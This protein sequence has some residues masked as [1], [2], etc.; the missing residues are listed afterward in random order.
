MPEEMQNER[1]KTNK[2][3]SQ[4]QHFSAYKQNNQPAH[5]IQRSEV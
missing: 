2:F 3:L 1:P 5:N 4:S